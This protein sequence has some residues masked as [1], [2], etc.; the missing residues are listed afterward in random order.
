M[1]KINIIFAFILI[2]SALSCNKPSKNQEL[3]LN[4]SGIKTTIT[5]I[6]ISP[7]AHDGAKVVIIGVVNKITKEN[8]ISR[9]VLSDTKGSIIT[10]E[11]SEDLN[12]ENGQQVLLGG[13]Y[14]RKENT[15]YADEIHEI[16]PDDGIRPLNN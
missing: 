2:F 1:F 3:P 11:S 12:F 6:Q 10:A 7:L 9:L 13:I 14:R 8:N 15:I 5:R 4:V 16:A